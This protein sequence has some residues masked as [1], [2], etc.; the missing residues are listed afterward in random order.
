[1]WS[2]KTV[3][4]LD[5]GS[6]SI[7]VVGFRR[8]K[9]T[10]ILQYFENVSLQKTC[11]SRTGYELDENNIVGELVKLAEK[12]RLHKAD[13]RVVLPA[14]HAMFEMMAV[15][16][17]QMENQLALN[18]QQLF[19]RGATKVQDETLEIVCHELDGED[20]NPEHI[21]LLA[22]AV[23][24]TTIDWYQKILKRAGLKAS[25]MDLDA[26]A[27]FNAFNYCRTTVDKPV[28]IVHLGAQYSI[29]VMTMP[30]GH[31][32]FKVIELAG[33]DLTRG[34]M[35]QIGLHYDRA[36]QLK[37]KIYQP[38]WV[39]TAS[40]QKSDLLTVYT[41][42]THDLI[43]EVKKCIRYYQVEHG[44]TEQGEILLTGGG[45]QLSSLS[46]RFQQELQIDTFLWDPMLQFLS[47]NAGDQDTAVQDTI[48]LTPALGTILRGD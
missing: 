31:P 36:E 10:F 47:A 28:T 21:A 41:E 19:D 42:F 15:E 45:A 27:I 6:S 12:H 37:H 13:V 14:Q 48:A 5:I 2:R 26:L 1:M 20:N 33:N 34:I 46:E 24:R 43:A 3:V 32:F 16:A 39:E 8:H 30:G 18:L 11:A 9:E 23:Q 7:K 40:Y 4:G 38:K 44:T 35:K 25:I 17:E 29:C 22:C